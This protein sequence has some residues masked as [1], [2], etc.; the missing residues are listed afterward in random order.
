MGTTVEAASA[1]PDLFKR[2]STYRIPGERVNGDDPI[3]V[4][5]GALR[6]LKRAREER[7][8]M[9]LEA[10]RE[11]AELRHQHGLAGI[12]LNFSGSDERRVV[13]TE[14]VGHDAKTLRTRRARRRRRAGE[15]ESMAGR[16]EN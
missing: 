4:R 8:P 11:R 10:V 9:L 2:G 15:P 12:G 5:D 6:A 16:C 7:Q 3:A 1:E 14:G 13:R